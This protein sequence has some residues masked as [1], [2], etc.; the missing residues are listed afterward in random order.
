VLSALPDDAHQWRQYEG[1]DN[2]LASLPSEAHAWR[3]QKEVCVRACVRVCVLCARSPPISI[4]YTCGGGGVGVGVGGCIICARST[5]Y[6]L[7]QRHTRGDPTRSCV[8][9]RRTTI[10]V[11]AYCY[12]SGVLILLTIYVCPHTAYRCMCAQDKSV[13]SSR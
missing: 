3:P 5:P 11:S 2:V 13:L 8:V 9:C 6:F 12:I 4:I 10:C 7:R 1:E